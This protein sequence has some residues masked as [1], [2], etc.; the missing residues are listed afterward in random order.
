MIKNFFDLFFPLL[1][2]HCKGLLMQKQDVLCLHCRLNLPFTHHYENQNTETF[3]RFFGRMPVETAASLLYFHKKG[4]AQNLI[5]QLKYKGNQNVGTFLAQLALEQYQNQPIFQN[6]DELVMVPL[7]PKRLK[8][9]GYNQ[10]E[11]FAKTIASATQ[12]PINNLILYKNIHTKTQTKKALSSRTSIDKNTFK[13]TDIK[14]N[15]GKHFLLLDD[16][17]TSGTTLETC[18]KALLEIPNTKISIFTMAYTHF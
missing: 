17:M 8:K 7:H 6:F 11:T 1:C 3:K 13:I 15:I 9:R 4:M 2:N 10:V 5:H 14:P 16:V 12:K 18:G